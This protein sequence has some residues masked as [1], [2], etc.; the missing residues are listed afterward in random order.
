MKSSD[1]KGN[2]IAKIF[3]RC[4]RRYI[5]VDQVIEHSQIG[6][7]LPVHQSHDAIDRIKVAGSVAAIG[8]AVGVDEK[9]VTGLNLETAFLE[10]HRRHCPEEMAGSFVDD[11]P[12]G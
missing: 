5:V 11:R 9:R 10:Q 4:K 7:A 1:D 3:S 12:A 2:V 8:Q 6:I